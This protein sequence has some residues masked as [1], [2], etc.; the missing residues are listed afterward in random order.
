MSINDT[1]DDIQRKNSSILGMKE[2]INIFRDSNK[3][4]SDKVKDYV[5]QKFSKIEPVDQYSQGIF[6]YKGK[7]IAGLCSRYDEKLKKN[8]WEIIEV[9]CNDYD[10]CTVVLTHNTVILIES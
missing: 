4:Q 10:S 8:R 3:K 2:T 6:I 5:L 1:L 7:P 9:I